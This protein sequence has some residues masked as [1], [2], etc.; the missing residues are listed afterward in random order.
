MFK[1]LLLFLIPFLLFASIDN[2]ALYI[3]K[4]SKESKVALVI[5]NANYNH[6]SKLKNSRNDA[7]DMQTVLESKG[8]KVYYLQDASLRDMK[9]AVRDFAYDIKNGGVGMVYYAGH[10]VE[11][12]GKNYLIPVDANIP[13]KD[14]VEFEALAVDLIVNKMETAKNRLNIL[15]LDACRNDPFSRSGGGGLAAINNAKGMYV[16]YATAPGEVASDG[17]DKNGL[18]TKHLIQEMQK[19]QTLES[20]FKNTRVSVMRESNERQLPWTS[21]SVMG[22]FY[23]TIPDG[24]VVSQTKRETYP[25]SSNTVNPK[26]KIFWELVKEENDIEHYKLYLQKYPRGFYKEFAKLKIKS[27]KKEKSIDIPQKKISAPP[28]HNYEKIKPI[29]RS[30]SREF[31]TIGTGGVTG[32][33]YPTG[34]AICRLI[35]I[36]K[37]E[38]GVRCSVESSG[39]SIYNINTIREGNFE[40]G[41]AQSDWHYHAYYGTTRFEKKGAFKKLRSIFS[42]HPEPLNIIVRADS[43][44]NNLDDLKDK[45]VH[46]PTYSGTI[47]MF[48]K[49]M[50]AKGW[51]RS[52][53]SSVTQ[54]KQSDFKQKICQN[55]ID[56]LIHAS[57]HPNGLI[58]DITNS[59]D[60]KLVNVYDRSIQRVIRDI[61]YLRKATV[62]G[63]IYKG[64]QNDTTSFGVGATLVTSSD[65]SEY[66][67]YTLVKSVFENF[68]SFKKLHPAFQTLKK[69]E[70]IKDSLTAPLHRG[71]IRYYKE[72]GLM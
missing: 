60:I 68:E 57:G 59:C 40:I 14:E 3:K 20:V 55:K 52:F 1:K 30:S 63:G 11:V 12:D 29:Q 9:K 36:N 6:F 54:G 64:N 2:R 48:E 66:A 42:I 23:F 72:A 33:Y 38:H 58:K 53:F 70:M 46:T 67:I 50:R 51:D 24:K 22:E 5:G 27:L 31:I 45:R 41:I 7:K 16:A 15:V 4:Y 32:V 26:E 8:F 35:N 37:K 69:Q 61:S 25:Q 34:G 56:A 44:I 39:G 47:K 43:N 10:G 28:Q 21:S 13:A 49:V 62:P 65:V 19:P 71:A 18:F 17:K